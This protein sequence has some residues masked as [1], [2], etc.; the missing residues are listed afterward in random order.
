LVDATV[1]AAARFVADRGADERELL[2]A[3]MFTLDSV[4]DRRKIV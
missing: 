3:L 1:M 4:I 2:Q